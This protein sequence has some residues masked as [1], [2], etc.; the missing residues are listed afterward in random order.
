MHVMVLEVNLLKEAFAFHYRLFVV[1]T[2]VSVSLKSI[3]TSN[4]SIL[5]MIQGFYKVFFSCF[6]LLSVNLT[7]K[8]QLQRVMFLSYY[9]SV[10][11]VNKGFTAWS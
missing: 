1:F 6:F 11:A 3:C 10:D 9:F 4:I 7:L 5:M 8:T 2:F